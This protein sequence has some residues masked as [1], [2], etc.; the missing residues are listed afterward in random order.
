MGLCRKKITKEK[1]QIYSQLKMIWNSSCLMCIIYG[2]IVTYLGYSTFLMDLK[3][4]TKLFATGL[5]MD[6]LN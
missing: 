6:F 3:D 2:Y 4:Y 1:T 5:A